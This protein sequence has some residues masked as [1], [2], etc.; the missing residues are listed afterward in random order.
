VTTKNKPLAP[1]NGHHPSECEQMIEDL[2]M[3][4]YIKPSETTDVVNSK[5][6]AF[7]DLAVVC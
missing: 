1:A 6:Q 2:Y 7:S 3:D 5:L 4:D